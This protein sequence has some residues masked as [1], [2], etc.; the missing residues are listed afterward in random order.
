M[1]CAACGHE[2]SAHLHDGKHGPCD[3]DCSCTGYFVYGQDRCL[4]PNC[5]TCKAMNAAD[6]RGPPAREPGR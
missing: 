4:N 3:A 6:D 5:K 1:G 2:K